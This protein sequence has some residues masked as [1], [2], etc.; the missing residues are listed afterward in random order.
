MQEVH[1]QYFVSIELTRQNNN[2]L[3]QAVDRTLTLATNV[4]TDRP[5]DPGGA[6]ATGAGARRRPSGPASS[7][8]R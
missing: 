1:V 7:S 8:A 6:R 3:G 2:R 5:R 4:V